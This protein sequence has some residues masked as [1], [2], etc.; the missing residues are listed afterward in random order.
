MSPQKQNGKLMIWLNPQEQ[1][2]YE[3]GL[4]TVDDLKL[5]AKD[6]GPVMKRK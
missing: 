5:W 1:E 3:A 6:Q 2:K 4:F